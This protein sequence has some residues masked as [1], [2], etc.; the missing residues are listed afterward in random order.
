MQQYDYAT[1]SITKTNVLVGLEEAEGKKIFE[2]IKLAI[3]NG[4]IESNERLRVSAMRY[5]KYGD[6]D[7]A[8]EFLQD[9]GYYTATNFPNVER[10]NWKDIDVIK[11]GIDRLV[12]AGTDPRLIG[13]DGL[14]NDKKAVMIAVNNANKLLAQGNT[15]LVGYN[16]S[17]FDKPI[18]ESIMMKWANGNSAYKNLF[19]NDQVGLFVNSNQWIDMFGGT[20]LYTDYNSINK[21]YAGTDI[22]DIDK[23]RGQEWIAQKHY[24]K[25]FKLMGYKPHMAGDDVSV[26]LDFITQESELAGNGQT[27]LDYITNGLKNA[28]HERIT[29]TPGQQV[30]RAKKTAMGSLGGR[31]YLNFAHSKST[32]EIFTADNHVLHKGKIEKESFS[33]GYGI[34]KGDLYDILGISKFTLNDELRTSLGEISPEYSGQN[35]YRVQLGM[36]VHDKYKNTRQDDLVQNLV[37]KN[38]KE[39]QAFLSGYFDVAAERTADGDIKITPGM[40]RHFDRRQLTTKNGKASFEVITDK[41]LSD[42][43]KFNMQVLANNEKKAVS[44]ADNA[45]F[46][47]N[48]YK[49]V[50]KALDL[51]TELEQTLGIE[52]I[53]GQDILAIMSGKV[54][55]GQMSIELNNEQIMSARKIISDTLS[56]DKNNLQKLLRS[57]I[58]NTAIGIDMI[59]THEKMLTNVINALNELE[60]FNAQ[61]AGYKQELF[62]RVLKEVK[63]RAAE[64][65]YNNFNTQD[66]MMLGDKKLESTFAELKNI[67]EIDYSR[68]LKGDKV[69]Y[70]GTANPAEYAN[71][72]KLD[73]S[74]DGSM[75][76][77]IDKAVEVI[78]GKDFVKSD[79]YEKDAMVRMFDMLNNDKNLRRTKAFTNIKRQFDFQKGN[80]KNPI[81][82]HVLAE[83]ILSGM[84]ELKAK[85]ATNGFIN[86]DHAFMKALDGNPGFGAILNSDEVVNQIPDIVNNIAGNFKYT[87]VNNTDDIARLAEGLVKKHYMP[88]LTAVKNSVNYTDTMDILYKNANKEM[89]EYMTN[90][91]KAVTSIEGTSLSIQEDGSL[92]ASRAGKIFN[93]NNIPQVKLDETSGVMYIQLG[94]MKLQLNNELTFKTKGTKVHGGTRSSLGFINDFDISKTVRN[95]LYNEGEEAAFDTLQYGIN[96][97]AKVLR[98]RPT[99]N[100]FGGNDIDSNNFVDLSGIKNVLVDMFGENGVLN[101][102]VNDVKFADKD[103]A[104]VLKK[105]FD[106]LVS[107]ES[108]LEEMNP[109][110][111]RN[112]AKNMEHLLGIIREKGANGAITEEFDILS[113]DLGFTGSEKRVSE[114]IAMRGY[115]PTNSTLGIFDNT[116]RPPIT[117]SG[118]SF[119]L[120]V[121]DILEATK[122]KNMN[123]GVGNVI[124]TSN[125]DKRLLR[126]YSGIGKTTTDVMMDISYIDT[127]SLNVLFENSYAKV[128]NENSV[129]VNTKKQLNKA[130]NFVKN[131]INTFEQERAIDS[132]IHEAV[133][134]LRTANTQKLS[135]NYDVVSVL[136]T[137]E[138]SDYE[139]QAAAILDQRGSF[140]MVNGELV[141]NASH[142]R[143]LKRGESAIKWKGFADLNS[144]FASKM[145]TGVFNYNYYESDGTKLRTSE[146]N[147]IIKANKKAFEGKT[148]QAEK[149]RALEDLLASKN[150]KGQY[151]IEDI[152]AIGYV[153]TMTGGAEKGMTNVVY[154]S[155]GSYDPRVRKFF[156]ASGN[157]EMVNSKVLT[158]EA[159][160]AIFY[161]NLKASKRGLKAAEFKSLDELKQAM[162]KERHIHSELLFNKILNGKTHV[163]A[164]DAVV[165]H[166]NIGQMYQGALSKAIN[167]LSKKMENQN[168]AVQYI[169][170]L[171]N[172]NEKYQ[173]ITNADLKN[174]FSEKNLQAIG[175]KNINGRIQI[176]DNFKANTEVIS[177]LNSDRFKNLIRAIDEQLSGMAQSDRLIMK[178]VY[179]ADE[180]GN[181]TKHDEFFGSFNYTK[182]NIKVGNETIDNANVILY[183]NTRENLKYVRDAETQTGV[184]A[185]YFELKKESRNLKKQQIALEAEMANAKGP[186]K[187]AL[188]VKLMGVKT[189]LANINEDMAAYSGA[190]KTMKF[191]DQELAVLE[192]MTITQAHA[193]KIN[194]LIESGEVNKD[195]FLN[196]V[197][198]QGKVKVG[199]DGKL[200]FSN[201]FLGKKMLGGLTN[202][203]RENQ[204]Y[205]SLAEDLLTEDMLK[206]KSHLKEFFDYAKKHNIKLGEDTAEQLYQNKL[207][208][209]ASLFN[210]GKLVGGKDTLLE[211]HKGFELKSIDDIHFGVDSVAE[212]NLLIDLGEEFKENRYLAMPGLGMK[213]GDDEIKT[214][215]QQK[216]QALQHRV[217]DIR[218]AAGEDKEKI[219]ELIQRAVNAREEAIDS[220]N[221]TIYGKHGIMHNSARIELDAVSYRLKASGIISNSPSDDMIKAIEKAGL[222]LSDSSIYTNKSM[223]NGKTIAD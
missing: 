205:D 101:H 222:S 179:I 81:Q 57:S 203:L 109:E 180:Q 126:E 17:K 122:T 11:K 142:G 193:D 185:E 6:K 72:L 218:E 169:V 105:D 134:G 162:L 111:V 132:R 41:D 107:K 52:N 207:A 77:L 8:M 194:E 23:V 10:H 157:W 94:S 176:D 113:R 190:V 56:Y 71:I 212:K 204:F 55:K 19:E 146:I 148:T 22:S 4:T 158:D 223:I 152:S 88:S 65:S 121:D 174:G 166:G 87:E 28:K 139:K 104:K 68:L 172:S 110:L 124:T 24:G 211:A 199:E 98:Q 70:I 103:L 12:E 220:L 215:A 54:A 175:I 18:L 171:I 78:H 102:Y 48:S 25:R 82:Q 196:S 53:H 161:N 69:N 27:Y 76:K 38:E 39:M 84:K 32:G 80:F 117:Q 67:F 15:S 2:E 118:N 29:L 95:A 49:K 186:E 3:E 195:T 200:E 26:L 96:S 85:N 13:E 213:V 45:M 97:R 7:F 197:A 192:R 214:E 201:D 136:E 155:T 100:A 164:N 31:N 149:I 160:E 130:F 116:Q 20:K 9:K 74:S 143:L 108:S 210:K 42:A 144:S 33:A 145:Q 219:N 188:Q 159:T 37:F 198:F 168:D 60:G 61:S 183:S 106:Y 137:L 123:I 135:K 120:R 46:K 16:D 51:K 91:L 83:S 173:F 63:Y 128:I 217:L 66:R 181:Y 170:D 90:I 89:N 141:Y 21:L 163:L 178:D 93:I 58:D 43:E 156:E 75:Y 177:T 59:S 151:A 216:L 154:A 47:S 184:N 115:R 44:R 133:Y 86:I 35:L 165:K 202:Q 150:I 191:G 62:S 64:H 140:S 92:V 182:K 50:S 112:I 14:R 131:T 114:L 125:M 167:S 30:L 129:D 99:I 34:G 138:G 36:V 187:N 1:K 209:K 5:A 153:K 208:D 147:K 79:A 127:D 73:L 206:N 189:R 40:E 221:K 119:Q